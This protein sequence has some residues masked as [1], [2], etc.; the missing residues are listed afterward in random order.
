MYFSNFATASYENTS[1][2]FIYF[3]RTF[4]GILLGMNKVIYTLQNK[5]IIFCISSKAMYTIKAFSLG[6]RAAVANFL[7]FT[8][9]T[10]FYMS[11]VLIVVYLFYSNF[12]SV[13]LISILDRK[14]NSKPNTTSILVSTTRKIFWKINLCHFYFIG[15][16]WQQLFHRWLMLCHQSFECWCQ[17][18]ETGDL[19]FLCTLESWRWLYCRS[20]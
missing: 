18:C 14:K 1:I 20:Q 7:Q 8:S 4:T 17:F 2:Y 5:C 19:T 3:L 10:L 13:N 6:F 11:K 15:R 16:N 9:L 12:L